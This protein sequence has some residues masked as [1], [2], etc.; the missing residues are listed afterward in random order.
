LTA[1]AV[2]LVGGAL[3]PLAAYRFSVSADEPSAALA[4]AA[5]AA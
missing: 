3:V 4:W 1:A 2:G 5:A